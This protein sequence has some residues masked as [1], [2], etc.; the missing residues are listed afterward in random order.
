MKGRFSPLNK[1]KT[2]QCESRA[3]M[4]RGRSLGCLHCL[5]ALSPSPSFPLPL[6]LLPLLALLPPPP[7]FFSLQVSENSVFL[8]AWTPTCLLFFSMQSGVQTR[9]SFCQGGNKILCGDPVWVLQT[10]KIETAS[11]T[12]NGPPEVPLV[13]EPCFYRHFFIYS[14]FVHFSSM[15]WAS[16]MPLA[17]GGVVWAH[18]EHRRH[19]LYPHG[20]CS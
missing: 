14:L 1:C 2:L 16:V 13:Q 12:R 5:L 10:Q 6:F 11:F 18:R 3:E 9:W 19:G 8:N 4:E 20:T 7:A 17:L 15:F